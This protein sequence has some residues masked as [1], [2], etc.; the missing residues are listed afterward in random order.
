M[1]PGDCGNVLYVGTAIGESSVGGRAQLSQLIR[2]SLQAR[3]LGGVDILEVPGS[4]VSA[5]SALAALTRGHV[6]GVSRELIQS[7]HSTIR[8]RAVR[9]VFL[10]GSNL[11]SIARAVKLASPSVQVITFFHN[12]E[13]RFFLGAL[14]QHPSVRA[15]GVLLANY[16]A[17]R[18]AVQFSD[19]RICLNERDS[20]L[21]QRVYGRGASHLSPMA[22]KDQVSSGVPDAQGLNGERYA[23]FVGG[24]FYANCQGIE[25]Y[26]DHVA[27]RAPIRT[28]V[29]GKG[30][31][32]WKD[33]LERNGNVR[34]IGTVDSLAP[35]YLGAE[36]VIAPIFDGSGMKTK[37]AEA[38]M[39]GRRVVGT[40]EAFVGYEQFA[41]RVGAVC[42][43]ASEFVAALTDLS[44]RVAGDDVTL[45]R[46][47]LEN[48]SEEAMRRNLARIFSE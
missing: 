45:R 47:Y 39:Y 1:S 27:P 26:V 5:A 36:F 13:A 22:L 23:L 41:A 28:Y 24:T 42:E 32:R 9:T 34:V 12:C 6:D 15:C 18:S 21:L 2:D 37:V 16:L 35:W 43:D 40:S 4:K 17:E 3:G 25:W 8:S 48:Y 31:E 10:D 14:R 11:G 30:F 7:I 29:V 20:L 38:L 46:I 33:R 44:S 19:K